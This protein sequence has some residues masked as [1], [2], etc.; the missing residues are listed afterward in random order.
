LAEPEEKPDGDCARADPQGLQSPERQQQAQTH[1]NRKNHH[2]NSH[3]VIPNHSFT[4]SGEGE[5]SIVAN[6]PRDDEPLQA[7]VLRSWLVLL[8][9]CDSLGTRLGLLMAASK[10]GI[11]GVAACGSV[12]HGVAGGCADAAQPL[13]NNWAAFYNAFA[14]LRSEQDSKEAL[15]FETPRPNNQYC[16]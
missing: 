15:A 10:Q 12:A 6:E 3:S 11:H 9:P 1:A 13:A 7:P 2:L 14:R 4:Q 8:V 5:Y 16:E